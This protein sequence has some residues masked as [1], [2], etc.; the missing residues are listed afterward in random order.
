[1]INNFCNSKRILFLSGA[2]IAFQVES[3]GAKTTSNAEASSITT[4]SLA[5]IN[6]KPEISEKYG[7]AEIISTNSKEDVAALAK[8]KIA[9]DHRNKR[10]NLGQQNLIKEATRLYKEVMEDKTVSPDVRARA[11]INYADIY[12]PR[13]YVDYT[14]KKKDRSRESLRLLNEVIHETNISSDF[15]GWARRHLS[16]LYLSNNFDLTPTEANKKSVSLLEEVCKDPGA[17]PETS[18]RTKIELAKRYLTKDMTM[19]K[20]LGITA[21]EGKTKAISLFN[22]VISDTKAR[23]DLRAE[24]KL[25]LADNSSV[26]GDFNAETPRVKT[27]GIRR[28]KLRLPYVLHNVSYSPKT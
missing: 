13:F 9:D 4:E 12:T 21:E 20:D 18:G 3:C 19:Q 7:P 5:K 6:E 1:M 26:E 2:L 27:R 16:K 14:L 28:Y 17:S 15:K 24:A 10:T 22:E 8:L 25:A 11:K 23:P